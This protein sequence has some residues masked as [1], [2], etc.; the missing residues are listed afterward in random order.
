MKRTL[1]GA[2]TIA[3]VLAGCAQPEEA[4]QPFPKQK[5]MVINQAQG[6][7]GGEWL[8]RTSP[9]GLASDVP[10]GGTGSAFPI[11]DQPAGG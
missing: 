4:E 5:E 2:L 10:P 6:P 8:D 7:G 1:F 11:T 3:L 9:V